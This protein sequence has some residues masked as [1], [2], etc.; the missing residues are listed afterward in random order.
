[1]KKAN[2]ETL[3]CLD[4]IWVEREISLVA[5]ETGAAFSIFAVCFPL[6]MCVLN[7]EDF[8]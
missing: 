8:T 4:E 7:R 2:E 3:R 6:V 5:K 1:M